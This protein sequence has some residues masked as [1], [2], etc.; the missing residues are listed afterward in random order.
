VK[1]ITWR[2]VD[3]VADARANVL[4][5]RARR[6]GLLFGAGLWFEQTDAVGGEQ[7]LKNMVDA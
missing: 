7:K 6:S 3:D 1:S 2:T 5:A 4:K